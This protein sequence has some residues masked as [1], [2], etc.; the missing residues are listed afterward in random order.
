MVFFS[1]V[2]KTVGAWLED[3][4]SLSGRRF[5]KLCIVWHIAL[6]DHRD[7]FFRA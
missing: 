3:G 6:V 5:D 2:W 7:I 1:P 4:G